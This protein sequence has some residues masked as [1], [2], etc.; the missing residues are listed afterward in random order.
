MV[1][2]TTVY[3]GSR[4]KRNTAQ[5][6]YIVFCT[7]FIV[8]L[9]FA[10]ISHAAPKAELW[11]YWETHDPQSGEII[12]HKPWEHFQLTHVYP[13]KDG[14]YR[15]DYDGVKK[16]ARK[17]L[18]QYISAL[19]EVKVTGLNRNEQLAY[20]IN[21]Y[22]ALTVQVVLDAYPVSSIR[23]IDISPGI[24]ADGPWG[25]SLVTIE[26]HEVSLDDIEHRILRPIWKDPRIHYVVNCAS[27][28]CPNLR[29][30]AFR[31]DD[32]DRPMNEA[33]YAY[34][35]HPRGVRVEGGELVVSSIYDW[36]AEDFGGTEQ[37]VIAHIR[38]YA[39]SS[40]KTSL[41]GFSSI[42][43]YEYDWS[44]ND[45]NPSIGDKMRKRGS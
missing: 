15:V 27:I 33:A 41:Q 8:C 32:L 1:P 26:K 18:N 29:G 21:L 34:I 24:F 14:I 36:F 4:L 12:D 43:D 25:K 6:S 40:L 3:R 7:A 31:G 19:A 22:N 38:Q 10:T 45:V 37:G 9:M 28:G 13:G 20:W 44:L 17:S 11:A 23:D 42:D 39:K 2:E 16:T 35:N 5:P 30:H